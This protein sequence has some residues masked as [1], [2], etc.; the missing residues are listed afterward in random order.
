VTLIGIP[1]IA[2]NGYLKLDKSDYAPKEK[3]TVTISGLTQKQ[4]DDGAT[5]ALFDEGGAFHRENRYQYVYKLDNPNEWQ[6]AAPEWVG[7]YET[8]LLIMPEWLLSSKNNTVLDIVSFTVGGG[9]GTPAPTTT[10]PPANDPWGNAS[11]WAVPEL[12][13]ANELGLI[14]PTFSGADLT[15][16]ITRAENGTIKEQKGQ[17]AQKGW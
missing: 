13:K 3:I 11:G 9:S 10:P 14:P 17:R 8:R 6:L 2:A 5:I 7:N 15:K 12:R 16:P 1:T 4:I